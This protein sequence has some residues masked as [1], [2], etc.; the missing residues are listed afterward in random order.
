MPPSAKKKPPLEKS[1]V[2]VILEGLEKRIPEGLSDVE[3]RVMLVLLQITQSKDLNRDFGEMLA[4]WQKRLEEVERF[5]NTQDSL[6]KLQQ[7][8][9]RAP[10]PVG[11]PQQTPFGQTT[12]LVPPLGRTDGR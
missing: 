4:G 9:R 5:L 10:A 2:E 3:L 1:H 12:Q 11:P 6:Q 8:P 7:Q